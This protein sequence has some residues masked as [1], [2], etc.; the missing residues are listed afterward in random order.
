M[1][2]PKMVTKVFVVKSLMTVRYA[3]DPA[4]DLELCAGMRER[5][6]RKGIDAPA[7]SMA[8]HMTLVERETW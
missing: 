1:L 7:T 5:M 6:R 4:G 8:R 2:A 3:T